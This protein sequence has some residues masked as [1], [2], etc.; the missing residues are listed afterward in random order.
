M[1]QRTADIRLSVL[2]AT[3]IAA[4]ALAALVAAAPSYAKTAHASGKTVHVIEHANTDA[5]APGVGGKDVKGNILTFNN[6]VF[7]TANRR[8]V[9]HD[10]GF[11]VRLQV[12]LGIWECLWTTF[13]KG[14]QITV[15]GPFYDTRNSELSITGGTGAYEGARGQIDLKSRDGGKAYD[16]VFHLI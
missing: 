14:G 8:K 3:A 16:F 10:E 6:P 11:C 1:P 7:D 9:G 2:V 4:L 5:E 13:L 15:Q 12:K